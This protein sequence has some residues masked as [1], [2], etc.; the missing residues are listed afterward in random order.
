METKLTITSS[1]E[2]IGENFAPYLIHNKKSEPE[3][4]CFV[5]GHSEIIHHG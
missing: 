3:E 1:Y 5:K 2:P 4:N